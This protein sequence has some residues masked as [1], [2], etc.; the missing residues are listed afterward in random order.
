VEGAIGVDAVLGAERMAK[1]AL[2]HIQTGL[3][4]HTTR[5]VTHPTFTV[6]APRGVDTVLGTR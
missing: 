2:I 4:F 1:G 6:E 3:L 5:L